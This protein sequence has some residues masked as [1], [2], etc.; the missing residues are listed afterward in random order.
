MGERVDVRDVMCVSA[1]ARALVA[2]GVTVNR[3]TVLR[4]AR[5]GRLSGVRVGRKWFIRSSELDRVVLFGLEVERVVG[6][7]GVD[8]WAGVMEEGE[9]IGDA[10]V[11][12]VRELRVGMD[13][14]RRA[15]AKARLRVGGHAGAE[16]YCRRMGL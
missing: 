4:W 8:K 9:V 5:E 2:R 14:R 13:L 1:F 3:E 7:G 11:G 15:E 6:T 10:V 12:D 16:A